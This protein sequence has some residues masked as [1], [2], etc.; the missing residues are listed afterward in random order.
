M[1]ATKVLNSIRRLKPNALQD[2]DIFDF[3]NEIEKIIA[4]TVVY[5]DY[6]PITD[7]NR[8]NELLAPEPYDLIYFDYVASKID[9]ING[10]I[11]MYSLSSRQF[12][13]TFNDMRD[14]CIKQAITPPIV[15][16]RADYF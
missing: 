7:L 6:V 4:M 8:D 5:E 12:N 16:G 15:G 2:D 14:Y 10:N 11:E 3:L 13:L 9:M 1:K